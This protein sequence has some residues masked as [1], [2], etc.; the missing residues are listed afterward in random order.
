MVVGL[1][2]LLLSVGDARYSCRLH[3]TAPVP[4][5]PNT[6]C[7]A[8]R[9]LPECKARCDVTPGCV[10]IVHNV[11]MGCYLR[12]SVGRLQLDGFEHQSRLCVKANEGVCPGISLRSF[13]PSS[14]LLGMVAPLDSAVPRSA[15]ALRETLF[16][17]RNVF[18]DLKQPR[19]GSK[20]ATKGVGHD[21]WTLSNTTI[22]AV[23]AKLERPRVFIEVGCWT[24]DSTLRMASELQR[25]Y[26]REPAHEDSADGGAPFVISVDS[27]LGSAEFFTQGNK[28]WWEPMGFTSE[29]GTPNGFHNFLHNIA[30]AGQSA[31]VVPFPQV[32]SVAAKVLHATGVLADAIYIDASH[33]YADVRLDLGAYW[34]LLRLGGVLFGDDYDWPGVKQ[35]VDEFVAERELVLQLQPALREWGK[36]ANP[37]QRGKVEWILSPRK[38]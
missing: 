11:H 13:Q 10:A 5:L 31:H 27:W 24:G 22:L 32:S 15:A 2:S 19:R 26:A 33:E 20:R 9:S 28:S 38:C 8:L 1:S 30:A 36:P 16:G 7:P 21:P 23:I 34:E 29:N 6:K 3:T 12:G 35:A 37:G 25:S 18:N 14:V 17:G 4:C